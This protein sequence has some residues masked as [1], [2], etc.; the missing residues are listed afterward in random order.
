MKQIKKTAATHQKRPVRVHNF[1]FNGTKDGSLICT[2]TEQTHRVSK[3]V[4]KNNRKQ[5]HYRT[6]RDS[7][8]SRTH[9]F[10]LDR[11]NKTYLVGSN[12]LFARRHRPVPS[13]VAVTDVA[14]STVATVINHVNLLSPC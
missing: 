7:F 9:I 5:N 3:T 2:C 13:V 8:F 14:L 4:S 1:Q 11:V 10:R 6:E 12:W